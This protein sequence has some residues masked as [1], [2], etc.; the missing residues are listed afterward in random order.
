M[1]AEDSEEMLVLS[2][3]DKRGGY[4]YGRS[5]H[6]EY[7]KLA[8]LLQERYN[9]DSCILTCSGMASINAVFHGI[10]VMTKFSKKNYN[11]VYSNELY[12]DSPRLFDYYK[13][14]YDTLTTHVV[15]VQKPDTI[16]QLF[17]TSALHGKYNILF[18]ESCSNPNGVVFDFSIIAQLR[19][20]SKDLLVVV[21]N[22]WL[23]DV[24]FNPFTNF[25]VDVVVTSLTKY[26]GAGTAIAGAVL[27]SKSSLSESI[28]NWLRITGQHISPHNCKLISTNIHNVGDR[29]QSSSGLA[30]KVAQYLQTHPRVQSVSYPLLKSH[31]TYELANKYFNNIT[32][33]TPSGGG[34]SNTKDKNTKV[35]P[36]V[37]T[38]KVKGTKPGVLKIL[39]AAKTIEHK[40]SFG[41]KMSRTDPWPSVDPQNQELV[42]VRLSLGFEDEY[43]RVVKGLDEILK[44]VKI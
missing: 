7:V 3:N 34:D 22:T 14:N 39:K 16:V 20:L 27:L 41:A 25:D 6:P 37:L 44:N 42:I 21:D 5:S 38:F 19:K 29:I 11:L 13:T 23:T 30:L 1:E 12:C 28:F 33:S 36:S 43:S 18:V 35:G 32:A 40:T 24:V 9:K 8:T 17:S 26:Y 31:P 15:D 10:F 2:Q 4:T